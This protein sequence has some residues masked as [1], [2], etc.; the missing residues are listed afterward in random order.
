MA[1]SF[2]AADGAPTPRKSMSEERGQK[3]AKYAL[4]E[5]PSFGVDPDVGKMGSY[6]RLGAVPDPSVAGMSTGDD[7]AHRVTS[8]LDDER[9]RDGSPDTLPEGKREAMSA[10]LHTKGGWRDHTDGNRITTTRGD[11]VEVIGGNYK[12]VVLGR[13]EG[14]AGWDVSGGHIEGLGAKSCIKWVQTF[15]GTWRTHEWSEKGDSEVIQHGN[16]V[17]A[18]YGEISTSTTGS[19]DATRPI[20]DED[21]SVTGFASAPNPVITESTWA[22]SITSYTG[23]PARPVPEIAG[24]TWAVATTSE[25]N[26]GSVNDTTNVVAGLSSPDGGGSG[27]GSS[28]T[29][30]SIDGTSTSTTT[31]GKDMNDTTTVKGGMSTTTTVDGDMSSRTTVGGTMMDTTTAAVMTSV[32]LVPVMSTVSVGNTLAV[33]VGA[34]ENI[35][36]GLMLDITLANILSLSVSNT[37]AITLGVH[38]EYK[39]VEEINLSASKQEVSGDT[40]HVSGETTHVAGAYSV[41]APVIFLG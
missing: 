2:A 36:L 38:A 26:V 41:I 34:M 6:L 32:N 10:V 30:T 3:S 22:K 13:T 5:I 9:S 35:N 18:F 39:L 25:T 23:S 12:M 28:T 16:R 33:N 14:D 11:K 29:T 7:L 31:I 27:D 21:H 20:E 24:T 37:L 17:D 4:L 19:E 15:G 1:A 40:T 8:F